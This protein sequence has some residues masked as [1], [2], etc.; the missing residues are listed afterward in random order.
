MPK[1]TNEAVTAEPLDTDATVEVL[2]RI[3]HFELDGVMQQFHHRW[4]SRWL[5]PS[6][7]A[8]DHRRAAHRVADGRRDA[9]PSSS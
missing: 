4:M 5:R 3:L 2:N 7:G 6:A 9:S 1:L 8:R